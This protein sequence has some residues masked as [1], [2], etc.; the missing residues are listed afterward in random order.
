M[1]ANITLAVD[2]PQILEA[3]DYHDFQIV[4]EVLNQVFTERIK[5]EEIGFNYETGQYEGVAYSGRSAERIKNK[6]RKELKLLEM[7]KLE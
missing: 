1:S 3:R 4:E 6:R 7:A 5:V 2:F